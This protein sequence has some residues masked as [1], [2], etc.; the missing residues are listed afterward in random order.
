MEI[1]KIAPA[2]RL[3][4]PLSIGILIRKMGKDSNANKT[5]LIQFAKGYERMVLN[6]I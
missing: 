6:F 2:K 4:I 1:R 3:N 5:G